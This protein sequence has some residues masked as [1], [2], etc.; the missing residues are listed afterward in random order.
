M[1]LLRLAVWSLFAAV[2]ALFWVELG[3]R[4]A[5]LAWKLAYRACSRPG[6][7]PV[8]VVGEST[9]YGEPYA[10]AISFPRILSM[11]FGG[12]LR[13]R[14]LDLVIL[15][16]PGSGTEVQYWRLLRELALRPRRGGVVLVYA[17]INEC[18]PEPPPGFPALLADRSLVL[19]RLAVLR[20]TRAGRRGWELDFEHRLAKILRLADAYGYPVVL[21]TL[22]GNLREFQPDVSR[23]VRD[24][25][26]R[27]ALFEKALR[28]EAGGR[29][30]SAAAG[31]EELARGGQGDP[32]LEHRRARCLLELGRADEAREL[33]QK[34]ADRGGTKRPT[35]SQN[36]AIRRL[37]ARFKT[38]LAD[39]R[40]DFAR[41]A[42]DGLPGYDLFLD[43]HH[44]NLRGYLVLASSFARE[45]SRMLGEPVARPVLTEAEVR[46]EAGFTESGE[47]GV[48]S[49]RF[50]WFCGE[51]WQ[52][53][54]PRE[55]L[56]MARRYMNA[57]ERVRGRPSPAYRFLLS[58][59]G[60]DRPGLER[61]LRDREAL[62]RD[63]EALGAIGCN[64]EW[65][66]E[67][68]LGADLPEPLRKEA[69]SVMD[70]AA[71]VSVRGRG[72]GPDRPRAP[73]PQR[74]KYLESKKR[75]DRGVALVLSGRGEAG[76][77]ELEAALRIYPENAEAA[78]S[79]CTW[80][81]R[82]E[83][84]DAAWPY[85]DLAWRSTQEGE[86]SHP[87]AF[88]EQC[89]VARKK[90]KARLK[91]RNPLSGVRS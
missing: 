37:A 43:A 34:A 7:F 47:L 11:M 42:P 2:L 40:T 65:T 72:G 44:P 50:L 5:A 64:P 52:R 20:R 51:A 61:A 70:L 78:A 89:R 85:C 48:Y 33:F 90:V 3:L 66:R 83:A 10:P 88:V 13:G 45:I 56:R 60:R 68:V 23:G 81:S 36:E 1:K 24:D 18:S 8:Y 86:G 32:G 16:E 76:R 4:G 80:H 41:A 53:V 9:A 22:S 28:E 73:S 74:L 84:W 35:T 14:P 54:D 67:L 77:K 59:V 55:P 46:Q 75:A 49:S 69:Q 63:R 62:R 82:Q 30:R 12:R 87:D 17:G 71:R 29:W 79:L 27:A 91:T 31:Y 26:E 21:S 19:S 15:A 6:P 38:G 58:L 25:P 57:A 39:P